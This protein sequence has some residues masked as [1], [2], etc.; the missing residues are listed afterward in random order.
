MNDL[1]VKNAELATLYKESV[2]D[3]L[4]DAG[5]SL[6]V[7]KIRITTSM[8]K[9]NVLA[10]G[11]MSKIGKLYHTELKAD[12]DSL[13]VNVCYLGKFYLPDFNNPDEKK[14]TYVLGGVMEDNSPFLMY[15]KGFS[16]QNVWDFISEVSAIINRYSIPMYALSIKL[17]VGKRPH[18]KFK[19]VDVVNFEIQRD[20]DGVL[21]VEPKLDRAQSLK[22]LTVK[23]KELAQTATKTE[24][25]TDEYTSQMN[26]SKEVSSDVPF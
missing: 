23:F 10:D 13:I 8:S 24:E 16:L 3:G 17:S 19:S 7:P 21:K 1:I 5:E 20:K 2:K 18:E 14:L 26:V 6:K 12:F 9:E 25:T 15:V 11:T 4:E 22:A